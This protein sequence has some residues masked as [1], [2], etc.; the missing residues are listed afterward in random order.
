MKWHFDSCRVAKR[1]HDF[2]ALTSKANQPVVDLN[3]VRPVLS[4]NVLQSARVRQYILFLPHSSSASESSAGIT[5]SRKPAM[6]EASI[7]PN[8]KLIHV[9][10]YLVPISTGQLHWRLLDFQYIKIPRIQIHVPSSLVYYL[11][12]FELRSTEYVA[13]SFSI[14][15]QSSWIFGLRLLHLS[16]GQSL[17]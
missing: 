4:L 8:P 14:S 15:P 16:F 2:E 9:N 17:I 7:N 13:Y 1:I 12:Y 5:N 3:A 10:E 11:G 6:S